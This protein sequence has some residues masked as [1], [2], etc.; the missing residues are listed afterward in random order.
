[1]P[2]YVPSPY[3]YTRNDPVNNTDPTGLFAIPAVAAISQSAAH[4]VSAVAHDVA[5]IF[6]Q[7]LRASSASP[8]AG[9]GR[10]GQCITHHGPPGFG[11]TDNYLYLN[12]SD[13][14]EIITI[15]EAPS[16]FIGTEATAFG[17]P[18]ARF[19]GKKIAAWVAGNA[20][21]VADVASRALLWIGFIIGGADALGHLFSLL[22]ERGG[23]RGI[24]LE[25]YAPDLLP[26]EFPAFHSS[27]AVL[28]G[29]PI[30]YAWYQPANLPPCQSISGDGVPS[31]RPNPP[32]V[33]PSSAPAHP[34]PSPTPAPSP[35]PD[36][37]P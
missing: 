1:V 11:Y 32:P 37:A 9:R 6:H 36:P 13:T 35:T 19:L 25:W 8:P 29:L 26:L 14:Q 31:P 30:P 23:H 16:N 18:L 28:G 17:G 33:P 12:A 10:T 2:G 5:H 24:Y 34:S 15:L 4:A 20:A 22:N 21:R 7:V 27:G 3:P